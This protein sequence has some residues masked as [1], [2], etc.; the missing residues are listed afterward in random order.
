MLVRA[1]QILGLVLYACPPLSADALAKTLCQ[2]LLQMP[3]DLEP[4]GT[5]ESSCSVRVTPFDGSGFSNAVAS[6][7][8]TTLEVLA[9]ASFTRT[10]ASSNLHGTDAYAEAVSISVIKTSSN[11]HVT[12]R[13]KIPIDVAWSQDASL[14]GAGGNATASVA[15]SMVG[16]EYEPPTCD[17]GL[18]FGSQPI[19]A[20]Q[21]QNCS[22]LANLTLG[23]Q[24]VITS[25]MT[26][27]AQAVGDNAR[28]NTETFAE[29]DL[30]HSLHIG[31]LQFTDENGNLI[32]DVTARIVGT[33]ELFPVDTSTIPEP[34][35]I[36][37]CL[38]GLVTLAWLGQSR[39][40]RSR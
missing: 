18:S 27:Q 17:F 40:R 20:V 25:T 21:R 12:A 36:G 13:L 19:N 37:L 7:E 14:T 8:S 16:T 5:A 9:V 38:A 11:A 33:D 28:L 4:Q 29:F 34:G 6:A 22:L 24:F 39:A 1:I 35:S 30:S 31:P 10:E 32:T 15:L 3:I 23:D 26:A 2:G